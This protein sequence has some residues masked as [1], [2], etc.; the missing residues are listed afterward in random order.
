MVSLVVERVSLPELPND[1]DP[2]IGQATIGVIFG[3]SSRAAVSK[4]SGSPFRLRDGGDGELLEGIAIVV[5]AGPPEMDG[6]ALAASASDGAGAD[7]FADIVG[8][9]EAVAMVTEADEELGSEQL[10]DARQGCKNGLVR[11]LVEQVVDL[12]DEMLLVLHQAE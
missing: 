5:I 3:H 9:G 6:F 10:A 8:R 4:V 2:A 11:M 1:A 7:Q 12:I